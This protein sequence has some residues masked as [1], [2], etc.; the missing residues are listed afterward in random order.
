M[1]QDHESNRRTKANSFSKGNM[2]YT[3]QRGRSNGPKGVGGN[4]GSSGGKSGGAGREGKKKQHW[5]E[6]PLMQPSWVGPQNM[7]CDMCMECSLT[8]HKTTK[9]KTL[10]N[11]QNWTRWPP[12]EPTVL[13]AA[14]NNVQGGPQPQNASTPPQQRQQQQQQQQG[15]GAVTAVS[16]HCPGYQLPSW[17]HF[18][19]ALLTIL[20]TAPAHGHQ[21]TAVSGVWLGR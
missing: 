12:T 21:A 8:G 3:G 4:S 14:A 1:Q 15:G 16:S 6:K 10:K 2:N 17:T 20:A 11:K 7:T 5:R 19:E 13:P 9:C 18:V